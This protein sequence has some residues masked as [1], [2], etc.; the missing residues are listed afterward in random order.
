PRRR[1]ARRVAAV[2]ATRRGLDPRR[3]R[4][5]D[6]RA[7]NRPAGGARERLRQARAARRFPERLE[8]APELGRDPSGVA[9]AR[10]PAGA[11]CALWAKR[12]IFEPRGRVTVLDA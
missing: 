6:R 9:L 4:R 11:S 3:G 5:A 2:P 12:Q 8:L 1:P 10:A 7:S